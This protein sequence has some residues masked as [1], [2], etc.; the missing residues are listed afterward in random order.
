M[1]KAL[2]VGAGI[3]LLA[4]V[5]TA[6]AG[7]IPVAWQMVEDRKSV[8]GTVE[9]THELTARARIGGVVTLLQTIERR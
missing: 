6:N 3:S 5:P 4:M 1:R 2:I 8:I 9:P 7:D